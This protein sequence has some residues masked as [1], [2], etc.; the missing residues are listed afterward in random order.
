MLA[1]L[2]I[3]N[4]AIV[5]QVELL[6]SPGFNVLTGETGAGKSILIDA[7]SLVLGDR[8]DSTNVRTG[9]EGLRACAEFLLPSDPA[10]SQLVADLLGTDEDEAIVLDRAVSSAGRSVC[11]INGRPATVSMLKDFGEAL[12]DI[13]GQHEHQSL[14]RAGK[15]IDFLDGHAGEK[16][17]AMRE[18]FARLCSALDELVRRRDS[19]RG[20]EREL[21]QREDLLRFQVN[22]I[23]AASVSVEEEIEL[24]GRRNKLAHAEKLHEAAAGAHACLAGGSDDTGALALVNSALQGVRDAAAVD[25]S[26]AEWAETLSGAAISLEEA[27]R[28]LSGYV[29]GI[30]FDA[31]GLDQCESRLRDLQKLKRKYG[32]TVEQIL[33]FCDQAAAELAEIEHSDEALAQVEHEIVEVRAEMSALGAQLTQARRKAAKNLEKEVVRHLQALSLDHARFATEIMQQDDDDGLLC[34]GRRVAHTMHGVDRVQFLMSNNP[35]EEPRPL[36]K[37]ASGGEIS[38]TMLALK[39]VAAETDQVPVVIFDEIDTGLGGR[40][41]QVVGEYLLRLS[42]RCQVICVT[43]SPLLAA[44]AHTQHVIQKQEA[45]GRT[46]VRVDTLDDEARIG[47]LARMLG[48]GVDGTAASHARELVERGVAM[49]AEL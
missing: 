31:A 13:H 37:I 2:W 47:E 14:L 20:N 38:R 21:R 12:V 41:A 42:A 32:D 4:F 1:R 44:L 11:R 27:A 6:L 43:H 16:V 10:F 28:A 23:N 46:F 45:N 49:R 29:E 35:G 33:F 24:L 22:E 36:V 48:G 18:R 34:D 26:L 39:S 7:I 40:A 15:H 5:D 30:E 8:A 9:A 19:L 25:S 17:L 3:E